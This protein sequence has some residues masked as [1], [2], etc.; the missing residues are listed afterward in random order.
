MCGYSL[1]KKKRPAKTKLNYFY[2]RDF[3]RISKRFRDK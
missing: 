1:A 3:Q 2:D